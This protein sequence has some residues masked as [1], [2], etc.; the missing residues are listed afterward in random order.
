MK[1]TRE[2]AFETVI[3][4]DLLSSGY[5]PLL[6]GG[7]DREDALFPLEVLAFIRDTQPGEWSRLESLLVPSCTS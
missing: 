5:Y 4:A 6:P 1:I 2:Y 3:E 7:F